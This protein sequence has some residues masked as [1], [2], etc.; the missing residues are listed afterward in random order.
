MSAEDSMNFKGFIKSKTDIG[1]T[2]DECM[3]EK[4]ENSDSENA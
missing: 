4:I 1:F 2:L 3:N